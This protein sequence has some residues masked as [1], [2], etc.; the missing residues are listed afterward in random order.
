MDYDTQKAKGDTAETTDPEKK[1]KAGKGKGKG[2]LT[3][4]FE[5]EDS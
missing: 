4:D 3:V 1:G 2:R 5:L